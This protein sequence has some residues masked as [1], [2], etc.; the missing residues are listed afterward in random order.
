[1]QRRFMLKFAAALGAAA[2]FAGAQAE[3]IKVGVTGGPHAQIMEVVKKVAAKSG[4][5]VRIVE[6]AD[7]VQPNAALAAGDLDANSYQHDP[8][9]QAQVKD[10]GYKLIKV[11]D[12]VTFPM[13][14][15]S[16][17]VKS[18]AEL[19]PGAR[20]A[21]PNDPTNGGRALLLLQKQGVLKLRADA[22]LKATPLD[23]V[24]NPR[25]LKIVELDAAQIPRSLGD[26]DAAA[27]N[28][29]YAM[30]AGLKPKQDAIAIEGPNGPYANLI[31][32]READRN[33]P[34]VAKLVAA[35][36][37]PEVKQFIDGKFGGAVIAAW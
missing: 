10:R 29:N 24:D 37:S 16:K 14:I 34:W 12:T 18:L 28:T 31:A 2:L 35:Y 20:V 30:E 22:G 36:H 4:L 5:D 21:I 27:I 26:V 3:T 33:K 8:Y 6:F 25:K 1:M 23:I 19:K 32:I 17:R 11:A 9:L 7:Y 13:G 15:Y